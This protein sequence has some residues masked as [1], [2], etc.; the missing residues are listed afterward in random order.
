V[1]FKSNK[2]KLARILRNESRRRREQGWKEM[3]DNPEDAWHPV[4]IRAE[5]LEAQETFALQRFWR[6]L[7]S[8]WIIVGNLALAS[9]A[10]AVT[11]S[12]HTVTSSLNP[13][14][15][16]ALALSLAGSPFLAYLQYKRSRTIRLFIKKLDLVLKANSRI[17][18]LE[19]T[20]GQ[21]P[22]PVLA[23]QK[24]YR[25]DVEDVV[26][27]LRS[28]A[29]RYRKVHNRLQSVI[30]IGSVLTSA[31]TTASVSFS[32]VRWAAVIMSAIVGLAAGF[33]GYFK[34][35]ERS[36]N[37]Q[38]T[39]DAIEREY[40]SVELRVGRYFDKSTEEAYALFAEVVERLRDEQNKRQQQLDQPAEAK[41]DHERS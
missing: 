23:Q 22:D 10:A 40:E 15:Y 30:I 33:I 32:E 20:D 39:A 31:I 1:T 27:Q 19:E 36:Y 4:H 17:I 35:R 9:V 12:P 25:N 14:I 3:A 8:A 41:R 16:L 5:I 26:D 21:Q 7:G 34:Y 38:Q 2:D 28:D 37:L 24:R 13:W 18:A 11:I 29:N 6:R